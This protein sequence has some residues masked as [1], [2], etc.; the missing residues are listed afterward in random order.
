M[1]K[2]RTCLTATLFV[3]LFL[4]HAPLWAQSS[5]LQLYL[6]NLNGEPVADVV[7]IPL[8]GNTVQTGNDGSAVLIVRRELQPGQEVKLSA[9]ADSPWVFLTP[10][11]TITVP[12]PV[13]K[14]IIALVVKKGDR[15]M[16]TSPDARA[17]ILE[18]LLNLVDAN[19]DVSSRTGDGARQT[20][21]LERV[22]QN[23]GLAVEEIDHTLRAW[24][25][26][27]DDVLHLGKI[28]LYEKKFA[29]A[30]GHFE[31][32]YKEAKESY[33]QKR[34][35]LAERAFYLA[36]ALKG[37]GKPRQALPKFREAHELMPEDRIYLSWLGNA[38][39]EMGHFADAEPLQRKFL[40]ICEETF[41]PDRPE[42]ATALNNLAQLLKATNRLD[43]AEPLMRRA[44]NIDEASFGPDHPTVAIR[45]SNLAL[46]LEATN[47]L[48]EAEPL[49]RRALEIDETSFGPHH[50]KVAIRLNNLA[51]L[52]QATNR[53]D[54]AEPLMRRALKID[55][56]SFGPDHPE[57]ARDLNNLA[58]L[59]QATNR[60]DEAEPLMRRALKN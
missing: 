55:E 27:T 30:I 5:R 40:T 21:A 34:E 60:L 58:Q 48:D 18:S 57:V 43:E 50:P 6:K 19:F 33:E 51:Q 53:L 14:P 4:G 38:L 16:L 46:L 10:E 1:G 20:L 39:Y 7:V 52:L 35:E 23:L 44:L 31:K 12:D 41:G 2:A 26:Q 13:D 56:A 54:E 17:R 36:R 8:G 24:Q 42:V 45:L 11:F 59:L 37:K 3:F 47:R 29:E 28:A 9:K 15:N 25:D 32:S 49:I 22:A